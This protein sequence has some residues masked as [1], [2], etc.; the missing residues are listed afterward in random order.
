MAATVT[1]DQVLIDTYYDCLL[2]MSGKLQCINS[3]SSGTA[4]PTT[5]RISRIRA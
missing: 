2:Q 1:G 5:P 4:L 3:L